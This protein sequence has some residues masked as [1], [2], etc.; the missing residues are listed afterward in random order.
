MA[1]LGTRPLGAQGLRVS[2]LGLGCVGISELYG[3]R[4]LDES[5]AML[6]RAREL[7]VDFFD[8]ADVYG[9][10]HNE[11]FIGE[12]LGSARQSVVLATKFGAV[13]E[14]FGYRVNGRPEYVR[15]ACDASLQRLGTDVI[16]LYYQHRVDPDTPIEETV[17]AMARL[18]EAGKV[19]T[20]G[21]SEASPQTIRRACK[22]HPITALQTE[23]SL[24]SRDPEDEL[25]GLCAEQG[26]TFV[27]YSLL[28]RGFLTG[29]IKKIEDLAADDFRRISPRFQGDNFQKNL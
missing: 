7:G 5:R 1:A 17:G 21:L 26:I 18:V 4:E 24:W 22:I 28:G 2:A 23:Y 13:R 14:R 27:A 3:P 15:Q 12:V 16:D 8:T 29:Q 10:G 9:A 20:L 11:Q 6:H 19:R 25:L